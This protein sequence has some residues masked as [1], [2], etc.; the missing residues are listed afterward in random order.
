MVFGGHVVPW[1]PIAIHYDKLL[2]PLLLSLLVYTSTIIAVG[3]VRIR[4]R[5]TMNVETSFLGFL[6]R[7]DARTFG[8]IYL[9]I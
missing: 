2:P 9:I 1:Y 3:T 4:R 8:G 7:S 5:A 6:P